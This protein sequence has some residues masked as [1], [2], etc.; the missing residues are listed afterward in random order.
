MFPI[1]VFH[2]D[3]HVLSCKLEHHP[4]FVQGVG[5]WDGEVCE[6][7]WFD[8][9]DIRGAL[10]HMTTRNFLD[11]LGWHMHMRNFEIVM[12]DLPHMLLRKAQGLQMARSKASDTLAK[13]SSEFPMESFDSFSGISFDRD[14]ETQ[15][16]MRFFNSLY[17]LSV[18]TVDAYQTV[19]Q[20]TAKIAILN[21]DIYK[22][23]LENITCG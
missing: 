15:G 18:V 10:K 13:L 19:E 11:F 21:A 17:C 23:S 22:K 14:A 8:L 12:E 6:R 20:I 2:A 3:G 4:R 5:L 16:I 1:P 9:L 7:K